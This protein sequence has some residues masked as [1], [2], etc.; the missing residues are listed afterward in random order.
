MLEHTAF[1]KKKF[2][3]GLSRHDLLFSKRNDDGHDLEEENDEDPDAS[4][5]GPLATPAA[6][7]RRRRR[8]DEAAAAATETQ[9]HGPA[10]E[11]G[12]VHAD[13]G[14]ATD[15]GGGS[16][17][18]SVPARPCSD[19]VSPVHEKDTRA[20]KLRLDSDSEDEAPPASPGPAATEERHGDSLADSPLVPAVRDS[21]ETPLTTKSRPNAIPDSDDEDDEGVALAPA[22]DEDAA[23]DAEPCPDA[24]ERVAPGPVSGDNVPRVEIT[25]AREETPSE[26]EPEESHASCELEEGGS[27]SDTFYD[28]EAGADH[29]ADSVPASPSSVRQPQPQSPLRAPAAEE[30]FYTPHPAHDAA[31]PFQ[32]DGKQFA[33]PVAYILSPTVAKERSSTVCA[34]HGADTR[35]VVAKCACHLSVEE[36]IEYRTL[37]RM[38]AEL[39][40]AHNEAAAL[41]MYL[42]ALKLRS[43]EADMHAACIR[44]GLHLGLGDEA[45]Q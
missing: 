36:A 10:E 44:L 1:L 3:F 7:K 13:A 15:S 28:A 19:A 16:R 22:R 27:D 30:A 11:G 18:A 17:A 21:H 31:S 2:V 37:K 43:D 6:P 35:F 40:A 12:R 32:V 38:G 42:N 25:T 4:G 34:R 24:G 41:H 45:E 29:D 14:A 39:E 23:D 8:P 26:L 5:I 33:S 20:V 9:T